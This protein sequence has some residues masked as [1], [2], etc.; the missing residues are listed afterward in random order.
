MT[1][2]DK[3]AAAAVLKTDIRRRV[4]STPAQRQAALEAFERSGLSGP[5]FARVA[6]IAYQTFVTWRAKQK[7]NKSRPLA[8]APVPPLSGSDGAIRLVEAVMAAPSAAIPA[9]SGL[10]KIDLPGGASVVLSDA[11]QAALA[12][13]LIRALASPC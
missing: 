3:P 10:L 11:T 6:G 4:R 8:L 13:Q 5:Q 2:S 7:K 1:D 9:A 12:A